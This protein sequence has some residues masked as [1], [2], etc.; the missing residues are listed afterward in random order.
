MYF[1]VP[2][3]VFLVLDQLLKYWIRSNMTIGQSIPVIS[4]IFHIT[5]I[6]NPGAAFGILANHRILFLLLTIA[7]TG[8]M[9]YLYLSLRNK[10]S[11]AALSLGLVISGAA[12]N[13]ID[14][15]LRG[16]VTDMFD[17]QIWPIFNIADICIC[18]GIA[19]LCYVLIFKGEEL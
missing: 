9:V 18:I 19:I 15:F 11:L 10:K 7:I 2:M 4:G 3:L 1:Y 5:Y 12:G 16:T 13:F 6:E 8:I 17:F 14:R